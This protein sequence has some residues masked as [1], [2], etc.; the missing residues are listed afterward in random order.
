MQHCYEII[1]TR[2]TSKSLKNE[3]YLQMEL[4]LPKQNTTMKNSEGECVAEINSKCREK[5]SLCFMKGSKIFET[6]LHC[7]CASIQMNTEIYP[8]IN[9]N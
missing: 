2:G 3:I 4:L 9:C 6:L 7:K 5:S 1:I 8:I